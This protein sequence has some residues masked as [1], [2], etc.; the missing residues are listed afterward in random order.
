MQQCN[1]IKL[2]NYTTTIRYFNNNDNNCS[3]SSS[4]STN[5][6]MLYSTPFLLHIY[7]FSVLAVHYQPDHSPLLVTHSDKMYSILY[8]WFSLMLYSR[9]H[10]KFNCCVNNIFTLHFP[11]FVHMVL[12]TS[13]NRGFILWSQPFIEFHYKTALDISIRDSQFQ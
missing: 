6:I 3:S 13:G 4:S 8:E 10:S 11:E 2:K 12:A 7:N 1:I 9:L 5:N